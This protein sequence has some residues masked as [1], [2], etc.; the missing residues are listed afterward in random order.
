MKP[1]AIFINTSRGSVV[2]QAA[3]A[4]AI[5]EKGIRAGLDVFAEEPGKGTGEFR[6]D[7]VSVPGVYGIHHVGASTDQSQAAIAS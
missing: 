6:D 2:D 4:L 5:R 1:G 3:L 7:I